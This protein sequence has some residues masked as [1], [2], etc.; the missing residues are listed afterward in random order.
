MPIDDGITDT[1]Q[2]A[3]EWCAVSWSYRQ[4]LEQLKK[5]WPSVANGALHY[6]KHCGMPYRENYMG[7]RWPY[8]DEVCATNGAM[9]PQGDLYLYSR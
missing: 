9:N 1:G 5:D 2:S 8:C 7:T 6:C 3:T 4:Q